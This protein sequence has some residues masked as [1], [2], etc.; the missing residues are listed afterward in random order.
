MPLVTISSARRRD[1]DIYV[2]GT[3]DG[4]AV[5]AHLWWSALSPLTPAERRLAAAQALAAELAAQTATDLGI[6][7]SV[8]L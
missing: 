3:V 2:V 6:S 1:D 7:G 5:R 8:T 4:V